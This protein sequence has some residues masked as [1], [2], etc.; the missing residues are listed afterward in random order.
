MH[1]LAPKNGGAASVLRV[2][3]GV[4]FVEEVVER[5][6]IY[7]ML[8]EIIYLRGSVCKNL[9]TCV[10]KIMLFFSFIVDHAV[11]QLVEAVRY[12]PEGRGFDSRWCHWN[13]SLT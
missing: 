4:T 13:F 7:G 11:A 3:T 2:L 10:K 9:H 6:T 1:N 8:R 5:S 12:K